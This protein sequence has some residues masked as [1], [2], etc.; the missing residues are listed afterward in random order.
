MNSESGREAWTEDS[1]LLR[2]S[3]CVWWVNLWR[4]TLAQK[5]RGSKLMLG[6]WKATLKTDREVEGKPGPQAL[7][8]PLSLRAPWQLSP[9]YRF[10]KLLL[11]EISA[12][13]R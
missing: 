6:R 2:L 10:W 3:T 11:A 13:H 4:R 12:G 7:V 1:M 8:Q 9:D 5:G